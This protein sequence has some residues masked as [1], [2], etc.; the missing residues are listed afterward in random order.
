MKKL[1]EMVLGF[2]R[3]LDEVVAELRKCS[4]PSKPELFE[5][6]VMVIAATVL[7]G[8]FVGISDF[9]LVRVLSAVIR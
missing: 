3:F 1:R 6:T 5:S 9:G 8:A 4:W 7:L 2:R